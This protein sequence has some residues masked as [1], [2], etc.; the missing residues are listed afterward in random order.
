MKLFIRIDSGSFITD[1][2]NWFNA[3]PAVIEWPYPLPRQGDIF[4][5]AK[6]L[7]DYMPDFMED[8]T[9]LT[10]SVQ[11]IK[12]TRFNGDIVAEVNILGE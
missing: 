6:L 5:A 4:D 2:G 8:Y 12:W 10:Y 1:E 11:Y 7:T 3:N 9:Q